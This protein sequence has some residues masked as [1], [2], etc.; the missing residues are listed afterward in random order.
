MY[1]ERIIFFLRIFFVSLLFLSPFLLLSDGGEL[2]MVARGEVQIGAVDE[3]ILVHVHSLRVG[4]LLPLLADSPAWA[5]A[6]KP[7]SFVRLLGR[8]EAS[9]AARASSSSSGVGIFE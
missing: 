4:C 8:S 3:V 7:D 5:R 6:P 2:A 9:A 1:I